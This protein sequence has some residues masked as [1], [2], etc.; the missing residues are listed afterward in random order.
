MRQTYA[1]QAAYLEFQQKHSSSGSNY[2]R[3]VRLYDY[4]VLAMLNLQLTGYC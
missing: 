2:V 3:H 1:M 4:T